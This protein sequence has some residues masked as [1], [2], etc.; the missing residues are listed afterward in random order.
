MIPDKFEHIRNEIQKVK[1][2]LW[3]K[4]QDDGW[5]RLSRFIYGTQDYS[6]IIKNIKGIKEKNNLNQ[7]FENYVICRWYN[8]WTSRI[9]EDN[10][11]GEHLA[12]IP[13]KDRFHKYIDF[14]INKIN[15]DLKCSVFPN[16]F[17]LTNDNAI[18]FALKNPTE[19]ITWLY[20]QQSQQG[21]WHIANRLFIVFIDFNNINESWRLKKQFSKL[22]FFINNYLDNFNS[23]LF[24]IEDKRIKG[25]PQ[26]DILFFI[27]N[28]NEFKG[29]FYSWKN[30][31][32]TNTNE[33]KI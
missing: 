6:E 21:R 23:N 24:M 22:K 30:N 14:Y 5:D 31:K 13:E 32:I 4:R 16:K 3:P 11:F 9:I 19:L 8:F 7:E 26:S 25:N 27:K 10:I 29:I 28:N 18:N 17:N 12:V 33:L 20:L 15:F 1:I 2:Y